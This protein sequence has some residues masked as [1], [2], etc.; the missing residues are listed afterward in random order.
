MEVG[1]RNLKLNERADS[2]YQSLHAEYYIGLD[3]TPPAAVA[4]ATNKRILLPAADLL[5]FFLLRHGPPTL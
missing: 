3:T 4:P 1:V 2:E 5:I